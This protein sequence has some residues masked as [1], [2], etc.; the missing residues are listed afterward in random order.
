MA[1]RATK[2]PLGVREDVPLRVGKFFMP[3]DFVI[4]G[5][6]KD[7]NIP[8]IL[9]RPF[10]H[11]AGAV[12]DVKHGM[13]TLEVG[14]EKTTFNLDK[15]MKALNL[16]DPCFIVD[17]YC[18]ECDMKKPESPS[19]DPIREDIPRKDKEVLPN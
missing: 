18:R 2:K 17:N 9:V 13:L 14:D 8:I 12:I 11:T 15:T 19:K 1:D 3:V 7:S 5:I 10:L 4:M 16:N 6:E